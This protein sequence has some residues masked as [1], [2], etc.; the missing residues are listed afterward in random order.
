M[1]PTNYPTQGQP[2]PRK[3]KF[4][5]AFGPLFPYSK[6]IFRGL[7]LVLYR[8]RRQETKPKQILRIHPSVRDVVMLSMVVLVLILTMIVMALIA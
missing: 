1:K 2:N 4:E 6:I 8:K 3:N 5:V 7:G